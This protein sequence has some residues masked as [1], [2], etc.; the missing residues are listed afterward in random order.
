M[1]YF[2][3]FNACYF[4]IVSLGVELGEVPEVSE[5]VEMTSASSLETPDPGGAKRRKMDAIV[6]FEQEVANLNEWF[7]KVES[8][9]ELLSQEEGSGDDSFTPEEQIVL[10]EVG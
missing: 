9:L 7:E 1:T 3:F 4:Q 6:E 5:E 8:A 10:I 2:I